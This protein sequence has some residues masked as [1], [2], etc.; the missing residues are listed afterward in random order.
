MAKRHILSYKELQGEIN[1]LK[2]QYPRLSDDN[3][4]VLWFLRAFTTEDMDLAA[5]SL[6]GQGSD[7]GIDAIFIDEKVKTVVIVQAKYRHT[8]SDKTEKGGI[9]P[10]QGVIRGKDIQHVNIIKG[11][12]WKLP[13][14]LWITTYDGRYYRMK[15]DELTK[16]LQQ[17][18][19]DVKK[20][21]VYYHLIAKE[22]SQNARKDNEEAHHSTE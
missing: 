9:M 3:L 17:S 1:Y 18:E 5:K 2:E 11:W 14:W 6:C 7:K 19:F 8:I 22:E 15:I 13:E 16:V 20:P 12:N 21:R 4:F 10:Q